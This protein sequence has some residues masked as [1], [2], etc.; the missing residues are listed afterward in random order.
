MS[1]LTLTSD[2]FQS[3]IS[4]NDLVV[5]DFWASWC[6]PCRAFAPTFEAA[7]AKHPDIVFGKVDTEA[8]P[9]LASAFN[10]R[11]IPTLMLFRE[12]I[13]LFAEAGALPASA[14][15][16]VIEQAR[17]LDMNAVRADIA[18]QVA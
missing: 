15:E 4:D 12:Q 2:N 6:A 14:L 3:T 11:S 16:Q 17:A 13:I 10:I 9:D 18:R 7:A 8:F 5:V 1:P